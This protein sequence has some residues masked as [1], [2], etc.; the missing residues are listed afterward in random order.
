MSQFNY[1]FQCTQEEK[2]V[3]DQLKIDWVNK[4]KK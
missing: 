4:K 3:V 2:Y 1:L